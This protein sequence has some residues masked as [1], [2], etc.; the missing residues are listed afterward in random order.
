[1]L[2]AGMIVQ[3]APQWRS[4][5]EEPEFLYVVKTDEEKGRVDIT[6]LKWDER[7]IRPINTVT[8]DMIEALDKSPGNESLGNPTVR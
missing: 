6:P 2:R 3:I 8:T 7:S 5:H 1:M 4:A